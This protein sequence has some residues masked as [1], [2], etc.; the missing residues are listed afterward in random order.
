[1]GKI[2]H[3]LYI[4]W[5]GL[6]LYGGFRGNRWLKNR[7]KVFKQFVIPSLQAQTNKNFTLWCSWRREERNNPY[8]KELIDY[9]DEIKEFKTVHTF[10]GICFWDD[11]YPDDQARDRLLDS[12]HRSTADLLDEIGEVDSVY[13]TIQPSDDCYAS[14]MVDVVQ[15]S[16][17]Q[18]PLLK[19]IGFTKGYMMNYLTKELAEYN[20]NTNPPFVTIKFPRDT[21]INPTKHAEYTAIKK[22]TGEYKAGTPCPSHE[23]YPAVFGENFGRINERG[24]LVGCHGENIST[25]FNHP[26]KGDEVSQEVLKQFGLYD[27]L[28][29][30]LKVS[31]RKWLLRKLPHRVQRKLRYIFGELIWQKIYN[32]LRN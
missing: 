24:F 5:T 21:F 1:M 2:K 26:F 11:K 25:V 22:D 28:P 31:W 9:L 30:K 8:V 13:M 27:V 15:K 3:F 19:C 23:F 32:F 18:L 7:I 4:P 12:I 17:N 20:P 29:L 14:V 16:F 10:H 6:G